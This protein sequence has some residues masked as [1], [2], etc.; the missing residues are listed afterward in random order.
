MRSIGQRG[1]RLLAVMGLCALL[2]LA[3]AM[4]GQF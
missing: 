4:F 1:Q 2:A 3:L